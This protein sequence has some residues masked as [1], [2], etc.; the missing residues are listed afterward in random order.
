MEPVS[1]QTRIAVW[2]VLCD[3]EW[4]MRYYGALA[5]RY[6]RRYR[7]LRFVILIGLLGEAATFYA[8]TTNPWLFYFGAAFGILL[9]GL[10][11]WDAMSDYPGDAAILR[12]TTFV[13]DGLMQETAALWRGIESY[14]ITTPD[15][16]ARLQSIMERWT[17][18]TQQVRPDVDHQLNRQSASDANQEIVNRYA[19]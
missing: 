16:E 19:F 13:C 15:A 14:R 7:A 17:R 9:A 12:A 8:A 3:L 2:H 11:V 18:A 6:R 5:A 10:T 4:N 1:D